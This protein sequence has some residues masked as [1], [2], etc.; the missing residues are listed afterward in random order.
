[1][2][3]NTL[4]Q[5]RNLA[6]QNFFAAAGFAFLAHIALFGI[7]FLWIGKI[8]DVLI[9]AAGAGEGGEAGGGAIQ[10]GVANASEIFDVSIKKPIVSSLNTDK[11]NKDKL[12]NEVLKHEDEPVDKP[13]EVLEKKDKPD[14]E[15]KKTNLPV[16]EKPNRIWTKTTQKANST[17]TT[18]TIGTSSGSLK[19]AIR[20]G[21]GISD[22]TNNGIGTGLPGGSEYGRRIQNIL[23]RNFT[24]PTINVNGTANVIV[25]IKISRDGKVT[26]VTGGRVPKNYFKQL[27]PYEQLNYAAERAVIA[28]ALQGLPPF[29][30]N[31]LMGTQEAVAEIWFQYP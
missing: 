26:S 1:M 18:A 12:N 23:S 2:E 31:F 21:I 10:V 5:E 16:Q 19:P 24:P 4:H 9:I 17:E 7:I 25:Y 22:N 14:P 30:G 27:S 3:F 11:E 8:P 28:T 29:P 6:S 13:E 15:A 20:G